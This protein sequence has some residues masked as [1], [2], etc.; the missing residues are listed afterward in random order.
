MRRWRRV[1]DGQPQNSPTTSARSEVLLGEDVRRGC[2]AETDPRPSSLRPVPDDQ[3][4]GGGF[5]SSS[6]R[7]APTLDG[8]DPDVTC[9]SWSP[10]HRVGFAQRRMA[11]EAAVHRWDAEEAAGDPSPIESALAIDGID[12]FVEFSGASIRPRRDDETVSLV[13]TE[14]RHGCSVPRRQ[15][16][17]RRRWQTRCRRNGTASDL[18]LALWRRPVLERLLITGDHEALDRFLAAPSS[19]NHKV[20]KRLGG[21]GAPAPAAQQSLETSSPGHQNSSERLWPPG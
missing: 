11:Q 4:V 19:P 21:R 2:L 1:R 8:A 3:M 10:E 20:S 6:T 12:E 5:G 7:S 9:W 15:R 14:D 18:L 17:G 13:A 16:R